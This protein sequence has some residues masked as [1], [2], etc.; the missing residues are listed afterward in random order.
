MTKLYEFIEHRHSYEEKT[1]G[2]ARNS[3]HVLVKF[4]LGNQIVHTHYLMLRGISPKRFGQHGWYSAR[5]HGRMDGG[6]SA[7]YIEWMFGEDEQ[8][9]LVNVWDVL[10][11]V[12]FLQIKEQR[13]RN[14]YKTFL[15]GMQPCC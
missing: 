12:I 15:F 9:K 6:E 3:K 13:L 10:S 14:S 8:L 4:A 11:S 7:V 1:Y 5:M 2:E